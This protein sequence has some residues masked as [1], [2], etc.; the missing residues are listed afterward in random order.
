MTPAIT[1][2]IETRISNQFA[3]YFPYLNLSEVTATPSPDDSFV[4][5]R[6]HYKVP[7]FTEAEGIDIIFEPFAGVQPRTSAYQSVS[8]GGTLS[9]TDLG[10]SSFFYTESGI[11]GIFDVGANFNPYLPS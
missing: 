5:I 11:L 10:N 3:T 1:T 6:L 8:T 4:V 7:G 9:T 2:Q